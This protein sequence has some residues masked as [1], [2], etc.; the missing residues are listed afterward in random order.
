MRNKRRNHNWYLENRKKSR[1]EKYFFYF[2]VSIAF[3][4]FLFA[5]YISRGN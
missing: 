3:I 4:M 2:L 5:V 1:R